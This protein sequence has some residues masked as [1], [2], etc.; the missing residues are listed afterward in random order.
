MQDI[1]ALLE[2]VFEEENIQFKYRLGNSETW[3]KCL[4][5]SPYI[6]VSYSQS[7]I[8]YQLAYFEDYGSEWTDLS[9]IL[10]WDNRDVAVW[11]L[12]FNKDSEGK[13]CLTSY[14]LQ[15][16]PP[17]F[18][19]KIQVKSK[20]QLVKTCQNILQ[21]LINHLE[22]NSCVCSESF[23][24]EYGLSD[25]NQYAMQLG[26]DRI[27]KDELY[28]DVKMPLDEIKLHFGK[29][30]K[31]EINTGYKLWQ[32]LIL[33]S[34]EPSVWNE[35]RELHKAAAGRITRNSKSWDTQFE[36][37][38]S[39]NA[40]LVYLKNE[41]NEMIGGG[42][43]DLTR[44]EV[45]YSVG[46][47]DRSLFDKPLGSTIQFAAINEMKKR[48]ISWYKIG[49]MLYESDSPK[50]TEKEL[51]LAFFRRKFSTHTLPKFIYRF[52]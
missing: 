10:D 6:P 47:Y 38:K 5:T 52:K 9:L 4:E 1:R 39:N 49:N 46:A 32:V 42:F 36:N 11:P 17:L 20:K 23:I 24:S 27:V 26:V 29:S 50:P 14:G 34:D 45:N 41:N 22:L 8:D 2:N 30:L 40:F 15:I 28:L 7:F 19:T 12:T 25:W 3:D 37:I 13:P 16:L 48:N 43:F 35:F 18:N 33:D 51:A 44:D 21:K 31:W